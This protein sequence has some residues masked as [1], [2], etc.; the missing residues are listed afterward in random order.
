MFLGDSDFAEIKFQMA[1]YHAFCFTSQYSRI[2]FEV[3]L[4][5]CLVR[6][7]TA[8][9]RNPTVHK[10]IIDYAYHFLGTKII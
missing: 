4:Q 3:L 1:A 6:P 8:I 10:Q 5:A 9:I 2:F 7:E